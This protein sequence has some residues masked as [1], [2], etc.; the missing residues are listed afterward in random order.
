MMPGMPR[1]AWVAGRLIPSF[2]GRPAGRN[3]ESRVL[4]LLWMP[5]RAALA[6]H[7]G[8]GA[9]HFQEFVWVSDACFARPLVVGYGAGAAVA[10]RLRPP[11]PSPRGREE[12]VKA[13]ALPQSSLACSARYFATPCVSAFMPALPLFQPAGQTSP[14]SSVNCRASTMRIISSMLRPSGRSLTT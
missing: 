8:A 13:G 3:P 9:G 11:Q 12:E 6:R 4:R 5:G 7:D 10:P 14:C 2:R 1:P